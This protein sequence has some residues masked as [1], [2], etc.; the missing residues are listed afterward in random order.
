MLVSWVLHQ[1]GVSIQISLRN[2]EEIPESRY[3]GAIVGATLPLP[4]VASVATEA[5]EADKGCAA[6]ALEVEL[7]APLVAD[8]VEVGAGRGGGRDFNTLIPF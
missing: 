3:C 4:S 6:E 1:V 5:V 2:W 7:T 8:V